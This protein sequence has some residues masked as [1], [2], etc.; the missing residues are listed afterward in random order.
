M[1]QL[2]RHVGKT[3]A[4]AIV[5]VLMVVVALDAVGAIIDE[6]GDIRNDYTFGAVLFYVALKL[7]ASVHEYLP[8]SAL[9]G[10]LVGVGALAGNSEV[11]VMRA[12]GVS[13]FRVVGFVLRPVLMFAVL[14]M[15]IGEF[16]TPYL[17]Q[18]AEGQREFLRQG[19]T[20]QD[21]SS[22]LWFREQ[23]EFMHINAAYPGGVLFGV[24]RYSLNDDHTKALQVSF[25]ER[26]T[27][28]GDKWLE[29]NVQVTH[30][31]EVQTSSEKI[32]VREWNTDITPQVLTVNVVSAE[33]LSMRSLQTFITY[34]KQQGL[35][36]ARYQ[37]VYWGKALLPLTMIG[38]V[39]IA[40]S[41]VFG[42]LRS[43]TMGLRIFTGVIIGVLFNIAQDMLGPSSLV[44]G[45]HP[46]YAVIVPALFC[47]VLGLILLRRAG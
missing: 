15:G 3:V 29:E 21:S 27:F 28:T 8:F 16:V 17:D 24:T 47:S 35:D 42:P 23:N 4:V 11:V 18:Y 38:L 13:L 5:V 30:F 26:A 33:L 2:S 1:K 14:G 34:L 45:F 20:S 43:S 41:F 6:S 36:S 22:G 19:N 12:A 40:I 10:C 37:L 31:G 9:I 44:F 39:L 32:T 25:A 46:I 7:P